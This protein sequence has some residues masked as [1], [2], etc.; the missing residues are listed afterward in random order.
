MSKT[1]K[2][3]KEFVRFGLVGAVNTGVDFA[4]FTVLTHLGVLVLAAQVVSYS[5]GI[6]NSF[7]LNRTWTFSARVRGK[8]PGQFLGFFLW[9]LAVLSITYGLL[10][11]FHTHFAWSIIV[12]KIVATGLSM[13][14]NF[15]GNRW[16]IFK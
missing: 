8:S 4:V 7:F 3:P 12:S 9:N 2:A 1:G 5:C 13:I 16:L 6:L 10:V 15:A 14:I 11:Y